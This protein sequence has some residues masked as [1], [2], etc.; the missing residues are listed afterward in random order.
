MF[1]NTLNMSISCAKTRWITYRLV[2]TKKDYKVICNQRMHPGLNNA[3]LFFEH[4]KSEAIEYKES[5]LSITILYAINNHEK[6]NTGLSEVTTIKTNIYKFYL[7][8]KLDKHP[9]PL[10]MNRQSQF[11]QLPLIVKSSVKI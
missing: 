4:S 11:Q 3:F 2:K 6:F 8:G 10:M 1:L 7:Q 5:T 9:H